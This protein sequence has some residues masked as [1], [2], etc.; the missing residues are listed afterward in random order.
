VA[1]SLAAGLVAA[2]LLAFAPFIRAEESA[3][4]GAVLLGFALGW[5]MLA[6]LSVRFTDQPQRWAMVPALFMAVGGLLLVA[7]GSSAHRVL[8]WVWPPAL[9]AVAIWMVVRVRR[10]LRS[11]SGRRLLYPVIA[12][13][14][15]ASVG[16]GYATLGA[17]ADTRAYP[18]PGQ[19]ID[20][21]GHRLH[22][23]CTGSGSPTVV[24]QPGG[25]EMSSNMGWIAPAVAR[26]T[27]VCVQGHC[28]VV[29]AFP[30]IM[31]MA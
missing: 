1:G 8:D 29:P 12:F 7:F 18:M 26:S 6:V 27:R 14:A 23:N 10:E 16:G 15:L 20:V 21:G 19:L 28:K 9:L 3:V 25:G 4:T 30:V 22:L 17:A 2:L 13:L 31:P 11:R 5:A 24:L